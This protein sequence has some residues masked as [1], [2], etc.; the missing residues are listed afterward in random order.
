MSVIVSDNL[1]HKAAISGARVQKMNMSL[2]TTVQ[3]EIEGEAANLTG[4][5]CLSS[6][7]NIY[8]KN[9]INTD[10]HVKMLRNFVFEF[11]I[12]SLNP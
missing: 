10:C 1:V 12:I 7:E 3:S 5:N 2:K 4:S 11:W 8:V 6:K 9:T